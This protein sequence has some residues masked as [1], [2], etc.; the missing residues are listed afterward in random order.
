MD[1]SRFIICRAA[2]GSGKT[3]TLV[4]NYL[5]LAFSAKEGELGSRFSRILAITFTN[6]A[7]NEMK[8]RI[9]RELDNIA[10]QGTEA[11]MGRD[12]AEETHLDDGTLRRYAATVLQAILHN[13]SDFAVMTIDSFVHHIVRTFAHDLNLPLNFNVYIDNTDLIQNAIDELMA[14]VG[15]E[16]QEGLTEVLCD[17][18]ESQ[19]TEG[20]SYMIERD[21]AEKAKELFKEHTPEFL[22]KLERLDPDQ[23]RLIH[24]QL[25]DECRNYETRLAALGTKAVEAYTTMGLNDEDFFRGKTGAPSYFRKVAAGESAAPGTYALQYL[26][27][28]KLGGTKASKQAV[29]LL[30]EV[31]PRLQELHQAITAL[32]EAEERTYFTRK[33]L[34][35]NLYELALLNKLGELVSQ[36]SKENEIVHISEFNKRISKVVQE[37]PAPFIYERIGSHYYNYLID[38]FQDTSRMQ[39]QNMVPLVENG[40]GAGH[41]SLVVGDGKQA[42][43]RFRQGDVEQFVSLP[44]VDSELHGKLLEQPGV[45]LSTRLDRNFRSARTVVEFNNDFFE[46]AVRDRFPE[47]EE[48]Q[49]IYLGKEDEP[50]LAQKVTKEGGYVQIGFWDC[51]RDHEMLWKEMLTDILELTGEKGYSYRDITILARKNKVLSEISTFLTQNEIPI[52]SSESLLL[53]QSLVVMMMRSLLEYLIDDTNRIAA[54]R[55]LMYLHSL[56]KLNNHYDDTFINNLKHI[57]LDE[58]SRQEGLGLNCQKLRSLGL[59]DCCE[60]VLRMLDLN[61]IET[62]YTASWLNVVARYASNHRYDLREFLEWFDQEKERL[63]TNTASDL[64][65]V[66][67]MSIHKAKGLESPI[68]LYPILTTKET[69][70][71]IWVNINPETGLPLPASFVAPNKKEPTLFDSDY[72]AETTK[73]EMDEMNV[74]YVALTRPKEKLMIYCQAPPKEPTKSYISMLFDYAQQSKNCTAGRNGTCC[75][76]TNTPKTI[77]N[78]EM[79]EGKTLNCQINKAAFPDWTDRITIAEQAA[80]LFGE[81]DETSKRRGN[82]MHALLATIKSSDEADR[83]LERFISHN[84]VEEDDAKALK[85]MLNSMLKQPEVARFFSPEHGCKN[86]CDMV[87]HGTVLRPDRIVTT[88]EETWVIDFKTGSPKAEHSL[89]VGRYCEAIQAMGLPSVKGY[90]LYLGQQKCQVVPCE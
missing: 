49:Q 53:T 34:L 56:G 28:E 85:S 88:A 6:K 37:E 51:P 61:G 89:Q 77:K 15:C 60:E 65:A 54:A 86:E 74:L 75:W 67:L 40:V 29:A 45:S 26:E 17:Y 62:A 90:L 42:I 50:D 35:R 44:H 81:F 36:Y 76:G 1:K 16:G 58:I 82:L 24:K 7:A 30:E 21:L 20:K 38:E 12:L 3:Y 5:S 14:L 79:E 25:M 63:S 11:S 19:M 52:V 83:A 23:F 43:Y 31:K 64:D 80:E 66:R 71:S 18:A 46:W 87:W 4:R 47:N 39:W 78:S 72:Q 59:Y 2:A 68:V 13:Y 32:R 70:D 41:T 55:V 33:L 48:L 9:L 27:G 84:E 8:E 73:H 69:N 10:A 57:D 22:S